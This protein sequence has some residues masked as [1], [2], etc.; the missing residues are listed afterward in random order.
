MATRLSI[1]FFAAALAL[2]GCAGNEVSPPKD[3]LAD[4]TRAMERASQ[5]NAH[6]FAAFEMTSAERKLV[7]ARDLAR[8]DEDD[9]RREAARLAEQVTADARLAEAK[10]RLADAQV[11]NEETKKTLEALRRQTD[12]NAGGTP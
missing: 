12:P 6:E 9:D 3:E 2:A 7:R 5:V 4:A 10:A 1:Y 8:S 11:V